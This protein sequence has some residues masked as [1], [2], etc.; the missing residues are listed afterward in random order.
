MSCCTIVHEVEGKE[1][2]HIKYTE[3][4]DTNPDSDIKLKH[5]DLLIEILEKFRKDNGFRIT[6]L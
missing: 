2:H 1:D 5:H 4:Y 6:E 3:D